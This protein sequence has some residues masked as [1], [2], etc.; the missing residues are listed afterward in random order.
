MRE[1]IDAVDAFV[2][3]LIGCLGAGQGSRL[4]HFAAC[5]RAELAAGVM[6]G[7][8]INGRSRVRAAYRIRGSRS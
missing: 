4:L 6:I 1:L 8:F 2:D 5:I 3:T 7:L